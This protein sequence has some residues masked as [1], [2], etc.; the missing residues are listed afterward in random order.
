MKLIDSFDRIYIVN[1]PD[2]LDR[3]AEIKLELQRQN[4]TVDGTKVRYFEAIRPDNAGS[5]PSIGAKGCFLSHLKLLNEA[6]DDD[7][8]NVLVL[9]DDLSIDPS[10]I[11]VQKSL[12]LNLENKDWDF[13]YFGHREE[14]TS[15][16]PMPHWAICNQGIQTTHFYALNKRVMKPLR[17]YLESCL[18]REPG[19]PIGGPM[20][21]DGAYSMFRMQHPEVIT[22]VSVPSMG[23]QRSSKSDVAPEKWFD[24]TWVLKYPVRLLRSLKNS[25]SRKGGRIESKV[26]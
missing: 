21:V 10:F 14:L 8:N 3:K 5:F 2:R 20:H 25:L 26:D 15:S 24:K 6:I 18:K 23:G 11:E 12:H 19:D 9:E 4:I 13:A 17:D 1:L 22:L 7:L 16:Q